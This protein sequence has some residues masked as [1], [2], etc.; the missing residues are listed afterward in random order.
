MTRA[1]RRALAIRSLHPGLRLSRPAVA[2]ALRLLDENAAALRCTVPPGELSVVFL[3]D[4][5][6]AQ[7]HAAFLADPTPT[8][9]ITFVGSP[10]F[11]LA[12]EICLSADAAARFAAAG[13]RRFAEELTLY[14]A[15]GWLHLAG[16][17]DRQ[18]AKKRAMRRAEAR[19]MRVLR[20]AQAIPSFRLGR[21]RLSP[22]RRR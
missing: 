18:P 1:A 5:A 11:G 21:K 20:E 16:H 14:L 13:Q 8:D 9:V 12:G 19:A 7:L 15:H 17:D 3:T 2:R 22:A 6:L 4:S 10:S